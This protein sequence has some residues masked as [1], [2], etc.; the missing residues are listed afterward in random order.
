MKI[1]SK[2]KDYYDHAAMY[3]I[4]PHIVYDRHSYQIETLGSLKPFA[5]EISSSYL[6]SSHRFSH[7]IYSNI[8]P[9]LIGY[10]GNFKIGWELNK[11]HWLNDTKPEYSYD[12]EYIKSIFKQDKSNIYYASKLID[13]RIEQ[14]SRIKSIKLF[15]EINAP[16]VAIKSLDVAT[17]NP[18]LKDYE[19][20]KVID[21]YELFQEI[22]MFL[23]GTLNSGERDVVEIPD[24]YRKE[25]HGMDK[26]SFRNPDPPKRKMKRKKFRK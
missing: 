5:T 2:Y 14:Y 4:D 11:H 9:F 12:V 8:T 10:C 26:W 23:A 22:S 21:P 6:K 16:L 20:Q 13:E 15:K 18:K 24:K 17:V 19:F 1:I 3:G 7:K 25:Q